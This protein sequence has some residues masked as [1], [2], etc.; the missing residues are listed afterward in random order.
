M[1]FVARFRGGVARSAVYLVAALIGCA[2]PGPVWAGTFTVVAHH[3]QVCTERG[4]LY[5]C[6]CGAPGHYEGELTLDGE[7]DAASG[8][9]TV[10]EC[11]EGQTPSCGTPQTFAVVPSLPPTGSIAFCAGLCPAGYVNGGWGFTATVSR[12]TLSGSYYRQ[13][14]SIR[15]CGTHGGDFIAVRK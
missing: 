7:G 8:A 1:R 6:Q 12:D 10:R 9:L 14:G 11:Y 3:A 2:E 5:D 15:G 4:S 13:R